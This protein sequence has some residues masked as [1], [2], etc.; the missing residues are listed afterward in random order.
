LK[1]DFV[2]LSATCIPQAVVAFPKNRKVFKGGKWWPMGTK[3]FAAD[4]TSNSLQR[5]A[6]GKNDDFDINK[7]RIIQNFKKHLI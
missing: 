7:R 2:T 5:T 1:T 6:A 4:N 3:R